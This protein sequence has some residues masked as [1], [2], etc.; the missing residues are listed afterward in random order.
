MR[1]GAA[2]AAAAV[3]GVVARAAPAAAQTP[4]THVFVEFT[5]ASNIAKP[6]QVTQDNRF[7]EFLETAEITSVVDEGHGV[8]V[9]GRAGWWITPRLGI[10]GGVNVLRASGTVQGVYAFPSPFVFNMPVTGTGAAAS[11]RR[12]VDVGIDVIASLVDAHGWQLTASVGPDFARV[13]QPLL[14][15]VLT[16]TY[17]FPFTSI[18]LAPASGETSGSGVGIHVGAMIARHLGRVLDLTGTIDYRRAPVH[19]TDADGTVTVDPGGV[20]A[21]GGLRVR[22]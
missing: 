21:G 6:P 22:F 10:A 5:A 19:L 7:T 1:I 11:A 13:R 2:L 20:T 17:V 4:R 14:P 9:G 3:I 18:T 16:A 15:D 8:R 12:S